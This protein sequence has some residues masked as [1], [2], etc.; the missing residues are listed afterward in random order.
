MTKV[1]SKSFGTYPST[2]IVVSIATA[3]FTVGL[4]ML[5]VVYAKTLTELIQEN[6]QIQVYFEHDLSE[7]NRKQLVQAIGKQDFVA[8]KNGQPHIEFISKEQAADQLIAQTGEDFRLTLG[9]NPLRNMLIVHLKAEKYTTT[10]LQK[11]KLDLESVNGIF[12]VAYEESV[13]EQINRNVE[14]IGLLVLL[15]VLILVIVVFVLLNSAIRLA[16][17]SQRLIVR[18]MQLVGAT[19]GFIKKPFV[20]RAVW[21][22][23]GGGAIACSLLTL[24]LWLLNQ[25][26][27]EFSV[28]TSYGYIIFIYLTLLGL[29]S[30]ICGTSAFLAVGRYLNASL[31]E[32]YE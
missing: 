4:F 24:L 32:L 28:L 5:L 15:F 25:Q 12:E 30:L 3:L 8:Q 19:E 27:P 1:R 22:G 23:V 14:K 17:Y 2:S 21:Q 7:Q 9:V 16:V 6:I 10:Q 20:W 26:V 13:I 29:G 11:I 31:A 18:S